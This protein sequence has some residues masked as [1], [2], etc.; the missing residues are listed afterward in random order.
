MSQL[1]DHLDSIERLG[2]LPDRVRPGVSGA[3]ILRF[4][5][6]LLALAT[7]GSYAHSHV[8]APTSLQ[9]VVN[10]PIVTV[11]TPID[12]TLTSG[13]VAAGQFVTTGAMAFSVRDPRV[14]EQHAEELRGR[15]S[16][17]RHRLA[18]GE[19]MIGSLAGLLAD[20]QRRSV[21]HSAAEVAQLAETVAGREHAVGDALM[22]LRFAE[23]REERSRQLVG[24][25]V[26]VTLRL[27]EGTR[28]RL[29][30]RAA[31]D[32]ALT[33]LR[34]AHESLNAAQEGI[35][36]Q[37]GFGG[38][39]YS[40]QRS[41]EIRVRLLEAEFQRTLAAAEAESLVGQLAAESGRVARLREVVVPV[42]ATGIVTTVHAAT[43]TALIRGNPLVDILDC[44]KLYVEAIVAPGWF[45]QPKPGDA[46][47]I[48]M[49]GQTATLAGRV[50]LVRDAALSLDAGRTLPLS[51]RD[52]R[53]SLTAIVDFDRADRPAAN[54]ACP[55]GQPATLSFR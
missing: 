46:V 17:A 51:D 1:Q 8:L 43:G 39:A 53:R 37:G 42:V 49:Y 23:D 34:V 29:V 48:G 54:Q 52:G 3:F 7:L 26:A 44:E 27:E 24:S 12:G 50:R 5:L 36:L 32:R 33:E 9:G 19:T 11:R 22:S 4:T 31:L 41:D 18:A 28:D 25:G 35:F 6:L 45:G 20:L 10:A 55:V 38:S 14:D 40:Q 13:G 15:L 21:A 30:A 47:M 2:R 16:Q